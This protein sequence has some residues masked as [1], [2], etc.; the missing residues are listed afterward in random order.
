MSILLELDLTGAIVE[1]VGSHPIERVV[2][3]RRLALR[4]LINRL[5]SAAED[6]NV[7]GLLAKLGPPRYRS[8]RPRNWRTR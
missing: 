3:R 7:V 5:A 8:R 1:D 6:P 4:T 2:N